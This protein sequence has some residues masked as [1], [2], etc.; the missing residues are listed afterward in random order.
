MGLPGYWKSTYNSK[1]SQ[2]PAGVFSQHCPVRFYN[3]YD[4]GAKKYNVKKELLS[5]IK[6]KKNTKRG[7]CLSYE[8]SGCIYV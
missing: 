6:S 8:F 7:E 3:H 2:E 1:T 4:I 5:R